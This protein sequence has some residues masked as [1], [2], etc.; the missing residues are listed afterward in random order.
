MPF[1]LGK[2]PP[3]KN[4][5][6]L[7]MSTFA[8]VPLPTPPSKTYWEYKVKNWPMYLNDTLGCCVFAAGGHM[9]QNW[10]AHAG[11][12][13]VPVDQ[14][15][16]SAYES[17]GGYVPGNPSTDNGAA[18]TDFLNYWKTKGFANRK[19]LGWISV[20]LNFQAIRQAVYLFGSVDIGINV[21]SSA[22]DQFSAGQ[23]WDVVDPDGGIEGGHSIPVMGYGSQ[24]M[25]CIT[26]GKIQYMSN[27]FFTTY[28]DEAYAV[29]TQDWINQATGKNYSGFDLATLQADLK[30]L[31]Q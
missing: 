1:K 28:C 7:A 2:L 14:D 24:G 23:P 19:I 26:W 17:V 25:A 6:T 30:A 13:I 27:D 11:T 22:M 18:I 20:P 3:K 29:V 15:I 21:P 31:S 12:E 5:K 4:L 8:P 16:L 9:E 10:S